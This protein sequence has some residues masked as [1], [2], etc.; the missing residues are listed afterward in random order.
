MAIGCARDGDSISYTA[1]MT[2]DEVMECLVP[3]F[4]ERGLEGATISE[5]AKAAGLGKASLYHHFPDGKDEMLQA[6][7]A[8][9][10]EQLERD[11]FLPLNGTDAPKRR[12]LAV[13]G[14]LA[15]YAGGG[16]R[17]CLL[18]ILALGTAR[19]RMANQ[20]APRL[21]A[22]TAGI[23]RLYAAAGLS[24]KRAARAARDLIIRFHGAIVVSRLEGGTEAFQFTVRRLVRELEKL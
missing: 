21:Q 8:R 1:G 5:I 14:G 24:N 23:E 6:V 13:I 11:V 18:G 15:D 17:N 4:R 2:R 19:E 22:W 12:L 3:V 7:I 16:E 20:V 10:L 9:V